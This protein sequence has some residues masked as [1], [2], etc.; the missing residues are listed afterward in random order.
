MVLLGLTFRLTDTPSLPC[1]HRLP[2][3]RV[4]SSSLRSPQ[5]RFLADLILAPPTSPNQDDTR[6]VVFQAGDQ[7]GA[8]GRPERPAGKGPQNARVKF[9][10]VLPGKYDVVI[11]DPLLADREG[12]PRRPAKPR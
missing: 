4:R 1:Q 6:Q 9:V 11:V 8:W 10:P 5:A 3:R 7:A 12:R 2:L